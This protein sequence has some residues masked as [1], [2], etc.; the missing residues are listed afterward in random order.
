MKGDY[1][2]R[3]TLNHHDRYKVSQ[4]VVPGKSHGYVS[5]EVKETTSEEQHP[6]YGKKLC[7]VFQFIEDEGFELLHII[8]A[9]SIQIWLREK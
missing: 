3:I 5:D 2:V 8:D 9:G 4:I 7:D 1:L 6:L